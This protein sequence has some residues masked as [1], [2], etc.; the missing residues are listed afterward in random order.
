VPVHV[1]ASARAGLE[2]TRGTEVDPTRIIYFRSGAHVQ[3]VGTVIPSEAWGNF[4]PNRRAYPG[5]ERNTF[6]IAGDFTYT[7]AHWW[8]NHAIDAEATGSLSDTSA[9]TWTFTPVHTSDALKSS[10][11]EMSY[12]DF[13]STWGIS[14]PGVVVNKLKVTWTKAVGGEE[15]GVSFEAEL[16]SASAGT[17]IT[18]FGGSLSDRTIVNAIGTGWATYLDSSTM[19]ST[20]DTRI[21][22]AT[23]EVDNGFVY[24]DG[25]NA[26]GVAVEIV[27]AK[28]RMAKV[29]MQRYFSNKTELDAYIAKTTRLFR[30]KVTGSL[31]GAASALHTIQLD[32][33]GVP[34]V[35]DK[36]VDVDGLVY[37][38]IELEP[39]YSTA[40][41]INSDQKW[42]VINTDSSTLS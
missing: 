8:L 36:T 15:T 23:W 35:H 21:N 38:N 24:R 10:S 41:S 17:Q 22:Q 19:G 16:M 6:N 18:S 37:A 34:V 25:A 29:T 9:Y 26:S 1:L 5:L 3:D 27:R 33:V 32:Y 28:K 4:T 31:A 20:A 42:T 14:V 11:W 13:I 39:L 12:V 30:S 2:S 40:G 7:D